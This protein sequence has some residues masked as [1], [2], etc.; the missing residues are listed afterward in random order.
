MLRPVP[1]AE[2]G[3]LYALFDVY[4]R[5]LHALT[6]PGEDL[7][8]YPWF[9][10]Y[11]EEADRHPYWICAGDELAGFVMVNAWP[12]SGLPIDHRVAE[13]CIRADHRRHG[14]GQQTLAALMGLHPGQWELKVHRANPAGFAFWPR[15]V[16]GSGARDVTRIE[17]PDSLILRFCSP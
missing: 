14:L 13:F 17:W 5:D 8:P 16:E 9:D 10:A 7:E 2:K 6:N 1:L 12:E 4:R 11:W 15:A 3:D